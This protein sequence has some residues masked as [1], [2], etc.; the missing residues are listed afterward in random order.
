MTNYEKYFGSPE[1]AA[2]AVDDF[3]GYK[4]TKSGAQNAYCRWVSANLDRLH[5]GMPTMLMW[6]QDEVA[7]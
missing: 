1:K 7:E 2:K 3:R 4:T 6:L 5:D